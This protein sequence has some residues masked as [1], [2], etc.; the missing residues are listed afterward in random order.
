MKFSF[1][2]RENSYSVMLADS[3]ATE[4]LAFEKT[5][6]FRLQATYASRPEWRILD[7]RKQIGDHSCTKAEWLGETDYP[8][9]AWFD[10]DIPVPVGPEKYWGLPGQIVYVGTPK[11]T[12]HYQ[13]VGQTEEV[14]AVNACGDSPVV[15]EREVLDKSP[16]FSRKRL[17][18]LRTSG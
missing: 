4:C 18:G 16:G 15:V 14:P 2:W 1:R 7:E 12:I 17:R 5:D 8:V 3:S 6:T 13:L 9:I 10:P 11:G